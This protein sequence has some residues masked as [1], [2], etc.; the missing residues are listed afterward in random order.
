MT[1][2][3]VNTHNFLKPVSLEKLGTIN[4]APSQPADRLTNKSA[5]IEFHNANA[6]IYQHHNHQLN[7]KSNL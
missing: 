4:T 7:L 3:P 6:F 1:K 5:N 2:S